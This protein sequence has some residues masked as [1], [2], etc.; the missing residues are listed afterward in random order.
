[1]KEHRCLEDNP[2]II[3]KRVDC[4]CSLSEYKP[5]STRK[6]IVNPYINKCE[7]CGTT[8]LNHN[9]KGCLTCGL[10][11]LNHSCKEVLDALVREHRR[12]EERR[13]YLE[14]YPLVRVD[15]PTFTKVNISHTYNYITLPKTYKS[16]KSGIAERYRLD[17][18]CGK[19]N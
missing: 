3:C 10:W 18:N 15:L 2:C 12:Q 11:E 7:L 1:M 4:T 13:Q 8:D 5:Y 6:H 19:T 17:D 14:E 16:S 9:C